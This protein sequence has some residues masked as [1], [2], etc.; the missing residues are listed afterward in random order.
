MPQAPPSA[1]TLP[2]DTGVS[3]AAASMRWPT[4]AVLKKPP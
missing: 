4:P 1:A 2:T 3:M